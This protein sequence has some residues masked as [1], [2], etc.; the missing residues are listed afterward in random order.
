MPPTRSLREIS[1]HVET[2][3]WKK[4]KNTSRL[5]QD[6]QQFKLYLHFYKKE[7]GW[8]L[9]GREKSRTF[10]Q[11]SFLFRSPWKKSLISSWKSATILF[12]DLE[13]EFS[14]RFTAFLFVK[15]VQTI[16]LNVIS[17]ERVLPS[18]FRFPTPTDVR[19]APGSPISAVSRRW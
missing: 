1:K 10:P 8:S 19:I 13:D 4:G 11:I 16:W 18:A 15:E 7:D 9:S 5:P 17:A 6:G 3:Y 12:V 2:L 14:H